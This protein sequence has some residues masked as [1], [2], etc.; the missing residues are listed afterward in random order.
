[1]CGIA[2]YWG[3]FDEQFIVAMSDVLVHR[4]PDGQGRWRDQGAG[5]GLAHRRL[6]INELTPA[7]RQPM[8]AGDGRLRIT[9][10]GESYITGNFGRNWK[11]RGITLN[12]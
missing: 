3:D 5:V 12:I 11:R 1:M 7:G 10:N 9:S 6:S 2:G 4:G 8:A